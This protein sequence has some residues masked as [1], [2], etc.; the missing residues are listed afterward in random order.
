M[1]EA[2]LSVGHYP[3]TAEMIS[4]APKVLR[5]QLEKTNISTL[6]NWFLSPGDGCVDEEFKDLIQSLEPDLHTFI[7]MEVLDQ[8]NKSYGTRFM[9]YVHHF[10]DT[11]DFER[12]RFRKDF[13]WEA[14]KSCGFDFSF[15]NDMNP[16]I[17]MDAKKAKHR[18]FWRN[19]YET[20]VSEFFCS[21]RVADFIRD[22]N[23]QWDF[24]PMTYSDDD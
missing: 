1:H 23:P 4:N 16:T 18:H 10:A 20:G 11:L 24:K 2:R 19:T 7:P 6:P 14:G 3:A 22:K 12:T 8:N 15:D 17:V 13:G 21:D 9:H 5:L